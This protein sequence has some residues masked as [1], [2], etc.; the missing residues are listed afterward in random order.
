[1]ELG[2]SRDR[3]RQGDHM[4]ALAL[5][6]FSQCRR[7]LVHTCNVKSLTGFGTAASADLFLKNKDVS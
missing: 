2:K 1:M 6:T 3:S 5:S 7:L 4:R